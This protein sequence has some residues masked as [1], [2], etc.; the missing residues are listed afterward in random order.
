MN[1]TTSTQG[2]TAG[3][4]TTTVPPTTA[5][6]TEHDAP[7][8]PGRP[9]HL[10]PTPPGLWR[11]LLG[12]VV[13]LLAPFFGILIGSGIGAAEGGNRMDPLYWGFFIGGLI[14]IVGLVAAG[15]GAMSLIR[16]GRAKGRAEDARDAEPAAHDQGS[17]AH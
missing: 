17:E 5:T 10:V 2:A 6:Q 7:V 9:V 1:D 14:G 8:P 15:M 13:A 3:A 4:P 12:V 11:V 16:H